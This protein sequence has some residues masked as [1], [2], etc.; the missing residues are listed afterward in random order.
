MRLST[1]AFLLLGLLLPALAPLAAAQ[2][3]KQVSVQFLS[4]PVSAEPRKARLRVGDKATIEVQMPGNELSPVYQVERRKNWELVK[5]DAQ[6]GADAAILASAP[7]REGNRQLIVVVFT[8]PGDDRKVELIP[9]DHAPAGSTFRF[10]NATRME[11]TG[12]LDI[13]RFSAEP[14][15]HAL[16]APEA[17]EDRGGRPFCNVALHYIRDEKKVGFYNN[18]WRMHPLTHSIVILHHEAADDKIRMAVIREFLR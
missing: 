9:M 5:A 2:Q 12:E 8:D 15:D 11:I 17:S 3:A 10:V 14:G 18:K 1:I 7:M 13:E 6:A 16:V 4:V